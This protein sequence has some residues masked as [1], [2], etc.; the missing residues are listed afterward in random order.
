MAYAE[1]GKDIDNAIQLATRAYVNNPENPQ[2]IDT[3]AFCLMKAK[4]NSDATV[5]LEKAVVA[6]PDSA[7]LKYR[8]GAALID[9]GKKKDGVNY[10]QQALDTGNFSYADE[11]RELIRKNS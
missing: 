2:I 1:Q 9:S 4:R 6:H 8:L 10:L 3:L 7:L 5:I 11:A